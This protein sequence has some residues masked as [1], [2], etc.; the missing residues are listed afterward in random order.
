MSK[1]NQFYSRKKEP[2]SILELFIAA[3]FYNLMRVNY[4]KALKVMKAVAGKPLRAFLFS[5]LLSTSLSL[6]LSFSLSSLLLSVMMD[7][8]SFCSKF[9]LSSHLERTQHTLTHTFTHPTD[10]L[11]LSLSLSHSLLIATSRS[12][13]HAHAHTHTVP[14]GAVEAAC[15]LF[16]GGTWS[17]LLLL[18]I[19]QLDPG[20]HNCLSHKA[21]VLE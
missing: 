9:L 3:I 5:N 2:N 16:A 17:V 12:N 21:R 13:M 11:S 10:P 7:T 1:H 19:S 18:C 6:S 4:S 15:F 8:N 20:P 14:S